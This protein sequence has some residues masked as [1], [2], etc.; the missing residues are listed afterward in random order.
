MLVVGRVHSA[1][2]FII[3]IRMSLLNAL[4]FRS[5]TL[6]LLAKATSASRS[7]AVRLNYRLR[8]GMG[9]QLLRG[10]SGFFSVMNRDI[11]TAVY[12]IYYIP[13]LDTEP[14]LRCLADD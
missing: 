11:A 12:T 5:R 14:R 13:C 1:I 4:I 8:R 2:A 6:P 9:V 3:Y 10:R 7:K